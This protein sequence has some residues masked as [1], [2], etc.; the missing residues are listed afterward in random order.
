MNNP[1]SPALSSYNIGA[2]EY[3]NGNWAG[4]AEHFRKAVEADPKFHRA[5]A[6]LGMAYAE[7]GRIDDAIEAYRKCIDVA[8]DYHKA[9]NNIGELYRRKGLLDY[10]TMVFKMASELQPDNPLYFYNLGLTYADIGMKPQADAA[11][12]RAVELDPGN[13]DAA[14]ELAQ[15][16]FTA[17][18]YPQ[19][20]EVMEKF[21]AAAPDHERAPEI[22][23]RMT[24]LRRRMQEWESRSGPEPDGPRNE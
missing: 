23:A 2:A 7:M 14:S 21:M 17:A 8:S 19:A 24:L 4:A 9:Y 16:R 10:A 15:L 12:A 20:L 3:R 6:Y 18:Q 13:F 11:L 1:A 5:L 22:R